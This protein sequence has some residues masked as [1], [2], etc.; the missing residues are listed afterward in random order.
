[1]VVVHSEQVKSNFEGT[2]IDIETTGDFCDYDDS[3]RFQ[4]HIPTI[5]GYIDKNMLHIICAEGL[6]DIEELKIKTVQLVPKLRKPLFAFNCCFERGVL[7][8]FCGMVV[9]FD[10]ELNKD[11]YEGKGE[12]RA[13]LEIDNYDDPFN[14]VGR[15]CM[16]AW[17]KG[18]Y[19]LSIRH[20]RS[21]LLKERDILI[22]RGYR[23]PDELLLYGLNGPIRP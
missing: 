9:D 16:R 6:K 22:K 20:N 1:M 18:E 21:C 2:I 3:R 12:V 13:G 5:F 10:G 4:S 7:F 19:G 14:D 8:H 11:R 15:D 17:S 23:S